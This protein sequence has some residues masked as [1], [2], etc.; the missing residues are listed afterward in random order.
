MRSRG[1]RH[2]PSRGTFLTAGTPWSL[3]PFTKQHG[4]GAGWRSGEAGAESPEPT[5]H[6]TGVRPRTSSPKPPR[7]Q[8]RAL[9][10]RTR[11]SSS[12][13][14]SALSP[15]EAK[16]S[17]NPCPTF[18]LRRNAQPRRGPSLEGG[19]SGPRA[20]YCPSASSNKEILKAKQK[21]WALCPPPEHGWDWTAG[22]QGDR[23]AS[24]AHGAGPFLSALPWS[25]GGDSKNTRYK[26]SKWDCH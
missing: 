17:P 2:C 14:P 9:L 26:S 5:T 19:G 12:V 23:E 25:R 11:S 7:T 1:H 21:S 6:H 20:F 13:V 22:R 15:A 16:W 10:G 8:A 4:C 3:L 24:G 18:W